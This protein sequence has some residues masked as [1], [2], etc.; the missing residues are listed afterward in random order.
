MQR[1]ASIVALISLGLA[2]LASC[3]TQGTMFSFDD[4]VS[5]SVEGLEPADTPDADG[6]PPEL[7]RGVE[8]DDRRVLRI[9]Q[10]PGRG[11]VVWAFDGLPPDG[12]V[13]VSIDLRLDEAD[14]MYRVA[15]YRHG[16]PVDFDG[17]E[18]ALLWGAQ[19]GGLGPGTGGWMSFVDETAA[20]DGSGRFTVGIDI[21]NPGPGSDAVYLYVDNLSVTAAD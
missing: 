7:R 18:P 16:G 10:P 9:A 5:R 21:A 19:G 3:A 20:A 4:E 2:S 6:T 12:R 14:G 13:T 17:H 11:R 8:I 1:I 15:L